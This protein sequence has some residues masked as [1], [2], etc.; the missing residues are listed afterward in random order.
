[1]QGSTYLRVPNDVEEGDDVWAACEVHEDLDLSLDLLLLH[2]LE[3]LDDALFGR[4]QRDPLEHLRIF[5]S[6]N[7][8]HDLVWGMKSEHKGEEGRARSWANERE[9]GQREGEVEGREQGRATDSDLER[10]TG[11]GGCLRVV[12]SPSRRNEGVS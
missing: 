1:V 9:D 8:A 3:H 6:S 10:P 2:R 11:P 4:R 5:S 7:L 12:D